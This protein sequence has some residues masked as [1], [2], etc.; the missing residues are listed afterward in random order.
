MVNVKICGLKNLRDIDMMNRLRPDYA[1][2][3][4]A[5][6]KRQVKINEAFAMRERLDK[7]I[8]SV[9]VFVNE[10][11]DCVS[12]LYN[13]GI[14]Q[15]AQLHGDEGME[16]IKELRDKVPELPVI[17]AVRVKS[18]NQ[19]LEAEGLDCQYLLLDTYVKDLYGGSGKQFDKGLVP[20]LTKPY[21][22]AGGL[23][24]ENVAEN[25]RACSP[26]AVDVSSAVET[27]GAKDEEKIKL[28]MER[29]KSC[30]R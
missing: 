18:A 15:L 26:F 25:I 19:I 13:E 23:N 20:K 24:A 8:L 1:G 12:R 22:L 30:G 7:D 3:V 2:F 10:T 5:D 14:I 6:S 16:Y 28:F 29:V 4:F 11:I 9:G 17:K 21:F 27:D